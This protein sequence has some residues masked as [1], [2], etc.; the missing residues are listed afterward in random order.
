VLAIP[1]HLGK[2]WPKHAKAKF[3]VLVL[4]K[5]ADPGSFYY[6]VHSGFLLLLLFD[7]EDGGDII[8][9]NVG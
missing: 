5:Q 7:P 2:E 4:N 9:R 1:S 3:Y 8:F 6:L